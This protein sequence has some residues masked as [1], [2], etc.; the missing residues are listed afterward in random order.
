VEFL[1]RLFPIL[2][3]AIAGVLLTFLPDWVVGVVM[4]LIAIGFVVTFIAVTVMVLIWV[5][6]K[7]V[8]RLQE[9]Y[10]P[11]RTGPFGLLQSVADA[12]KLLA[13]EDVIPARADRVVFVLAPLV[14]LVPSLLVWM[15][16]PFGPEM[17]IADL[18]IGVLYV[19]AMSGVPTLGFVMAGWASENKYAL[20]GGMRAAAQ[21][22]S[23]EIPAVLAALVPAVLAGSLSLTRIVEAQS[24]GLFGVIPFLPNW[25]IF[26][27][28]VGQVA[29]LL[30]LIAGTAEV[31]RTPF[32]IIEAESEIVAGFHTEYSGMRFALFFLA[33]YAN[34]L[35]LGALAATFF[36]GGWQGPILPPYV[37]FMAKAVAVFLILVWFRGTLPRLRYDQLMYFAWKRL[38]P[39]ALATVGLAGGMA[40][41]VRAVV[42]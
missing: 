42:G 6:R 22:L 30:F 31:N 25:F 40:V 12:V 18:D 15:V 35:A 26:W 2:R 10:G 5:E 41:L 1:N 36:F 27:P 24:G 13:K 37:W 20:L 29:F 19:I 28:V 32:D 23:Y 34:S 11:N 8:A 33:E 9:R 7:A 17:V 14:V 4:A 21:F 3:D 16:I 39:V 38:L